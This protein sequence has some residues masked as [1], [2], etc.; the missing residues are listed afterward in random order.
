MVISIQVNKKK[1]NKY[2]FIDFFLDSF[3]YNPAFELWTSY[4]L[5][6]VQFRGI[7]FALQRKMFHKHL[8]N[9]QTKNNSKMNKN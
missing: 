9:Q 1:E 8:K 2:G 6:I 5:K 7:A 4:A 3:R